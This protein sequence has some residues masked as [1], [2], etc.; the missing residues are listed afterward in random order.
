[1]LYVLD[2]GKNEGF[3]WIKPKRNNI[4]NVVDAHSDCTFWS[5]KLKL[6][7]VDVLLVVS[8]LDHKGNIE[9]ILQILSENKWNS[10]T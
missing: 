3:G 4:L 6:R 2:I 8:D 9:S 10:V 7:S 5:F 1:M